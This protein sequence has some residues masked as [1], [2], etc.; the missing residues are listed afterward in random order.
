MWVAW[1]GTS[2]GVAAFGAGRVLGPEVV[3]LTRLNDGLPEEG[4]PGTSWLVLVSVGGARGELYG[5]VDASGVEWVLGLEVVVL[6]RMNDGLPWRDGT[7]T[8]R[9][10]LVVVVVSVLA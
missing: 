4:G 7:G 10:A 8:S 9:P 3:V 6:M 2:G 5:R 1:G